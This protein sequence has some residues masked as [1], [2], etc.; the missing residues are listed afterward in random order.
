M[1][2]SRAAVDLIAVYVV[3]VVGLALIWLWIATR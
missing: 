1:T 3:C 2:V